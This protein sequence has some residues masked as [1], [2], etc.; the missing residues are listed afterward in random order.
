M[1]IQVQKKIWISA[2]FPTCVFIRADSANE[3]R[4]TMQTSYGSYGYARSQSCQILN[5]NIL[6]FMVNNG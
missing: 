3:N 4:W 2:W 1:I 6:E 5:F